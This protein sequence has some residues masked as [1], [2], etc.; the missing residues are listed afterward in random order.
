MNRFDLL[1][2][3][4]PSSEVLI[5]NPDVFSRII[6][7]DG[8][9][10]HLRFEQ[11]IPYSLKI[12]VDLQRNKTS[13][14][15]SGKIL[16]EDYPSLIN[17]SNIS[18]CFE[19]INATGI[20]RINPLTAIQTAV[21]KE[22]DVTTDISF[23]GNVKHLHDSIILKSNYTV[24]KKSDN[25]FYIST[26][27]VTLRKSVTLVVYDKAQELRS[28][29]NIPFLNSVDNKGKIIEYFSDK[30]RIEMNLRS[31][32]RIR[33]LFC[34]QDTSLLTILNSTSDPI[35]AFLDQCLCTDDVFDLLISKTPK[36][37]ELEHL[38]L[39]CTCGFDLNKVERVVRATTAKTTSITNNMKPYRKMYDQIKSSGIEPAIDVD[40]SALQNQI[41]HALLKAFGPVYSKNGDSLYNLYTHVTKPVTPCELDPLFYFNIP[42]VILP[43]LPDKKRMR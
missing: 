10:T 36:L 38:L 25:R 40:L 5:T 31:L 33:K 1:T 18:K 43:V 9:E 11:R 37:R 34:C 41:H 16:L 39:L 3:E 26:T 13:I 30:L 17:I 27:Y 12:C 21:V 22:C 19:T 42:T 15:F 28:S 2:L 23:D 29:S 14:L 8:V 32:D 7:K 6:S 4:L 20:C 24:S 35:A